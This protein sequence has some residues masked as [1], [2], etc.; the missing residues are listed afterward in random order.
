MNRIA[1]K[2]AQTIDQFDYVRMMDEGEVRYGVAYNKSGQLCRVKKLVSDG[3]IVRVA[4]QVITL[5]QAVAALD[6]MWNL[7][8]E[9]GFSSTQEVEAVS[10]FNAELLK[11]LP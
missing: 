10:K 2:E 3:N 5:K 1:T 11:A 4:A 6:E 8:T 7:E 9:H